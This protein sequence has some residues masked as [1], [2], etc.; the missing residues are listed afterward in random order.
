MKEAKKKKKAWRKET[1]AAWGGKWWQ[2]VQIWQ[3]E[4]DK[5]VG[6]RDSGETAKRRWTTTH[7]HCSF[8]RPSLRSQRAEQRRRWCRCWVRTGCPLWSELNWC[9]VVPVGERGGLGEEMQVL[10]C[11]KCS[12]PQR[13]VAPSSGD[14]QEGGAHQAEGLFTEGRY[15]VRRHPLCLDLW[16]DLQSDGP[17]AGGTK[18]NR[19]SAQAFPTTTTNS[20]EN[21]RSYLI[22]TVFLSEG[23]SCRRRRKRLE[24]WEPGDQEAGPRVKHGFYLKNKASAFFSFGVFGSKYVPRLSLLFLEKDLDRLT[25]LASLILPH[26][27]SVTRT[28][29]LCNC[30][31]RRG[32]LSPGRPRSRPPAGRAKCGSPWGLSRFHAIWLVLREG[33]RC[34]LAKYKQSVLAH[35]RP[36]QREKINPTFY[37]LYSAATGQ[38]PK[39]IVYEDENPIFPWWKASQSQYEYRKCYTFNNKL[40]QGSLEGYLLRY[41]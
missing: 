16:K 5:R 21:D 2:R 36:S 18:I 41:D 39:L 32:L 22:W 12:V 29:F 38:Q 3:E 34:N 25:D 24:W 31:E 27:I 28:I 37:S 14:V 13:P 26:T 11:G 8:G 4:R 30:E 9:R 20:E 6:A 7:P 23:K 1:K 19:T 10:A 17:C 33:S 35:V 15:V 40:Q